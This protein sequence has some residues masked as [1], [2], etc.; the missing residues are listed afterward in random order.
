MGFKKAII[1]RFCADC[2]IKNLGITG[3]YAWRRVALDGGTA[4]IWDCLLPTSLQC[5]KHGGTF[6]T[7][8]LSPA[9]RGD[10]IA[11]TQLS[12][13]EYDRS[14]IGEVSIDILATHMLVSVADHKGEMTVDL[15][16]LIRICEVLRNQV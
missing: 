8:R 13:L 14:L 5:N 15:F 7:E 16:P 12:Q 1:W 2:A 3:R 11:K 6:V 9:F 10:F 4:C